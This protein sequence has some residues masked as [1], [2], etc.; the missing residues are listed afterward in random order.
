M[1]PRIAAISVGGA[2]V[3]GAGLTAPAAP[4]QAVVACAVQ[5]RQDQWPGGMTVNITVRNLG[6]PLTDWALDFTFPTTGQRVMHGWSA[7][8]T[9]TGRDV[10][11]RWGLSDAPFPRV[12]TGTHTLRV[13]AV[14]YQPAIQQLVVPDRPE[15][16]DIIL[17][18][19]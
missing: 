5:Y 16:Y 7:T 12:P 4:A 18:S 9:Q 3:L 2:L 8:W 19:L 6:D 13:V 17:T 1:G 11:A 10:T 14:G 15:N